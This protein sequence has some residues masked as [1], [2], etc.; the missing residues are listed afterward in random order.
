M[1]VS[2]D[3]VIESGAEI[4]A[5]AGIS[6]FTVVDANV[7]LGNGATV[8]SHRLLGHPAPNRGTPPLVVR[9]G[10]L[11]RT[12][13][14]LY[15]GLSFGPRLETGPSVT[16]REW[17]TGGENLRLGTLCDLQGDTI[18]GDF[19]RCRSNVCIGN[20]TQLATSSGC[21]PTRCFA[22]DPHSPFEVRLGVLV[23]ECA[24]IG[25]RTVI[26]PGVPVAQAS[27]VSSGGDVNSGDLFVGAPAKRLYAAAETHRSDRPD[28]P[29]YP[30]C[31]HIHRGYRNAVVQ[32]W[33]SDMS[34]SAAGEPDTPKGPAS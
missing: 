28:L 22:N 23:E 4:G 10:A 6:P 5:G 31:A 15:E 3:A 29:A 34:K 33:Q 16:V 7:K 12:Y 8:G 17:V 27:V 13:S 24:A 32:V 21:F 18:I 30:W 25:V 1:T 26:L 19:V 20:H 9:R 14:V 2:P 11:I